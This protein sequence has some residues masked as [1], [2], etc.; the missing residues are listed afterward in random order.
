M[1]NGGLRWGGGAEAAGDAQER[2]TPYRRAHREYV[3]VAVD[4]QM[5]GGVDGL[6]TGSARTPMPIA[7]TPIELVSLAGGCGGQLALMLAFTDL[8][9]GLEGT[10]PDNYESS[11]V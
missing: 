3:A 2:L 1:E 8:G 11:R 10:V 9:H 7:L 5:T 4:Y 6:R